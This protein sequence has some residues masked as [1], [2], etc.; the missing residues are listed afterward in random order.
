MAGGS[1]ERAHLDF[2]GLMEG[3]RSKLS[4]VVYVISILARCASA[5]GTLLGQQYHHLT[6]L[7]RLCKSSTT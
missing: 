5:G 2:E 6:M 4:T 1:V 3:L 7:G